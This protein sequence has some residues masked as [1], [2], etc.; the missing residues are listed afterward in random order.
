MVGYDFTKLNYLA[1]V[2]N[3]EFINYDDIGRYSL[4]KSNNRITTIESLDKLSKKTKE[5]VLF[6]SLQCNELTSISSLSG[7]SMINLLRIEG[8]KI[9]TLNGLEN[10]NSLKYLVATDN[11]LGINEKRLNLDTNSDGIDD[12]KNT[13]TDSLTALSGKT[14]LEYLNLIKNPIIWIGYIS[15]CES[16]KRLNLHD[17]LNFDIG[18][19]SKISKIYFACITEY[20]SI[21]ER[22]LQYLQAEDRLAYKNLADSSISQLDAINKMSKEDCEKIKQLDLSNSSL[23]NTNLNNIIK[24]FPNLLCL[25]VD[26]CI[27]LIIQRLY[28]HLDVIIKI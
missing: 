5:A 27:N 3:E 6:L 1:V 19:V 17:C 10:M 22:F 20:R 7:F 23:S 9:T 26:G 14:S 18:D 2:G 15:D 13:L 4:E 12:G 16:I 25:N 24:K 28:V 11:Q 8:N 21:D